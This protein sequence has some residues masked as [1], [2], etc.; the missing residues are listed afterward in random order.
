[1]TCEC[2]DRSWPPILQIRAGLRDLPRQLVSYGDLRAEMLARARFQ[3]ALS[4]WRARSRDD[5]GLML[6]E[7]WAYVG[8]ILALYDKVIADESYLRT[9]KLRRS[10][11]RMV[12][13]LGYKPLPAVAASVEVAVIADGVRP[14]KLPVGTGFRS[15]AFDDQPPQV[16]ELTTEVTIHPALNQWTMATPTTPYLVGELSTLLL[17][18]A[19]VKLKVD[20]VVM[21]QLGGVTDRHVRKVK[22]LA[23]I[24]DDDGRRLMQLTLDRPVQA[25]SAHLVKTIKLYRAT[26]S[27]GIKG[28]PLGSGEYFSFYW[29]TDAY[30]TYFAWKTDGVHPGINGGHPMLI[31]KDGELR[32]VQ[33]HGRLERDNVVVAPKYVDAVTINLPDSKTASIPAHY[34]QPITAPFTY[35]W[36]Y[37]HLNSAAL[38]ASPSSPDW[39]PAA[40][41]DPTTFT[42]HFWMEEAGTL[43][44]PLKRT[45]HASDPLRAVG[46][47]KPIGSDPEATRFLLRDAEDRGAALSGGLD[48]ATGV[49]TKDAGQA[50]GTLAAAVK[51]YGNIITLIRGETV[52]LEVLGSGDATLSHQAFQLK[53]KPLTYVTAATDSGVASTLTVWV[54]GLEWEEVASLYTAGGSDRVY[55]V[56]QDDDGNSTVTFGDGLRGARLPTGAGNVVASYRHGAGAASPPPGSITQ[57]VKPVPGLRAVVAPVDSGGGADAEPHARLRALAPRSAVLLGRAISIDDLEA[58]ATQTPGVVTARTDW[59]WE[60]QRQRPVIRVWIIGGTGVVTTVHNRLRD[61]TEP[62]TPIFVSLAA[63]VSERLAID[64]ELDPRRVPET[65]LHYAKVALLGPQGWLHPA[66]L[67]IDQ[68][69]FRSDLIAKLLAVRGVTGVRGLSIFGAPWTGYGIAPGRGRYFDLLNTTVTGH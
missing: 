58:A 49:I 17:E 7:A 1:M 34:T 19:S 18:P 59:A 53:K 64:L 46:V 60:K 4:A 62:D 9:A 8:E 12:A 24:V 29:N 38:K 68:P 45:L 22:A 23:R 10:V 26:R 11:R 50:F 48:L 32:V 41:F 61:L 65:T 13:S 42:I 2:D 57:L 6:V 31:E 43:V 33:C 69:L 15:G 44:E 54:D 36:T 16:F 52:P 40:D 30:G 67:G 66:Q 21:I 25:S 14:V 56:A 37:D 5:F 51:G 3:Q 35:V 47:R 27:C 20:D 63:P 39:K 55:V 28:P